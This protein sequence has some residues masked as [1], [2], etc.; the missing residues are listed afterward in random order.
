M[1]FKQDILVL[2]G[3]MY[4][5]DVEIQVDLFLDALKANSLFTSYTKRSGRGDYMV[6]C[7]ITNE[8]GVNDVK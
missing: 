2:F 8:V 7:L 1:C 4:D 5:N 6:D 3:K